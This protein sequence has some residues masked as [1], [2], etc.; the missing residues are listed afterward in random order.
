[1]DRA[2]APPVMPSDQKA[3]QRISVDYSFPAFHHVLP[4]YY[5]DV[6]EQR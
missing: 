5:D 3:F 4:P 1:M 6:K 2:E